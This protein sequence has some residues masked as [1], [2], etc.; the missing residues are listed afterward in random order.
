MA[1]H[2]AWCSG[3]FL[4]NFG[5][6]ARGSPQNALH[7]LLKSVMAI[8]T[9][10]YA[11]AA[12]TPGL[13][14]H[15]SGGARV[16]PI[17]DSA[18]APDDVAEGVDGNSESEAGEGLPLTSSESRWEDCEGIAANEPL[19]CIYYDIEGAVRYVNR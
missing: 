16:A 14:P 9:T 12:K 1:Y 5:G 6:T 3:R 15:R 19:R 4:S 13:M 2:S 17:I 11:T 18:V 10:L 7:T 8:D